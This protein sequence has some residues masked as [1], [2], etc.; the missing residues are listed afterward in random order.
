MLLVNNYKNCPDEARG[1]VIALGNFDG[2]HRGHQAVLGKACRIASDLGAPSAVMTFEPHPVNLFKS[3]I[4]PFR[5]TDENTKA[6]L[7]EKTGIDIMFRINFDK[8]FASITADDFIKNILVDCCRVRHVVIGYDFIFGNKRSGNAQLLEEKARIYGFGFSKVE[9]AGEK[10]EVFSSTKVRQYLSEGKLKEASNILGRNHFFCGKVI[11]GD[12]RGRTI[13]FPTANI[14]L[15]NLLRPK[16]GVYAVIV[17]I[18]GSDKIYKAVANIGKKP[19]FNSKD[20]V[21][22]EVHIFDF[23]SNIYDKTIEVQ[24]VEY[25]R[26]EKRFNGIEELKGQIEKDCFSAKKF[27][28]GINS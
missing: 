12:K 6:Q 3:D 13:G 11:S 5:L 4:Q 1:A 7:I 9:S 24:L 10:E 20:D 17:K 21:G 26:E 19:T 14:D 23:N 22:L 18:E 2:I 27:L 25:I 16:N 8:E 15:G 28:N